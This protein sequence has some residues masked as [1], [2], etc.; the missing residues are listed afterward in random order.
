MINVKSLEIHAS[1]HCNLSCAHCMHFSPLEEEKY[2]EPGELTHDLHYLKNIV[3]T[4]VIRILGGEPLLN[5]K[6]AEL[7]EIARVSEIA[8]NVALATN[9]LLLKKWYDRESLW[10]NINECEISLYNYNPSIISQI[11]DLCCGLSYRWGVRFYLYRC[12]SFRKAGSYQKTNDRNLVHNL[13]RSCLVAH[14]WQ[15]VNLCGGRIYLCPQAMAFSR[16]IPD[17]RK[18]ENSISIK[19]VETLENRLLIYFNL[20]MPLPACFR[21]Y[22]SCG[23]KFSHEQVSRNQFL[24]QLNRYELNDIDYKFLD[25]LNKNSHGYSNL[26]TIENTI[27]IQNGMK[28]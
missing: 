3:H 25:E 18:E 11:Y 28:L 14:E 26:G 5:S 17:V 23:A 16:H 19:P 6:L 21:C 13:F 1:Y 27:I 22:G 15:C 7:A 2:L 4:D 10:K 20:D 24:E 12:T 8:D 9:G